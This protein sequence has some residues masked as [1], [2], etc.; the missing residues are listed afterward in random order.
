MVIFQSFYTNIDVLSE[1]GGLF[2]SFNVILGSLSFLNIIWYLYKLSRVF[3]KKYKSDLKSTL[4]RKGAYLKLGINK[5]KL[6]RNRSL[7]TLDDLSDKI[8]QRLT[9][10]G[11]FNTNEKVE[12]LES[13]N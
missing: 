4:E 7:N 13:E 11:L 6:L 8:S 5:L 10:I 3:M 9:Y 2:A 12:L 1:I